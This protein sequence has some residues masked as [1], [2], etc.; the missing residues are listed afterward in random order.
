MSSELHPPRWLGLLVG[1]SLTAWCFTLTGLLL[2][3]GLSQAVDL[4][5]V[6]EYVAATFF[7]GLGLLFGYWTYCLFTLRYHLDR[8]GLTIRWG[9]IHQLIP[10]DR[11]QKL[12]PGR[13]LPPPRVSGVSW[14]GHHVGRGTVE[15]LGEVMF[16]A[17]HRTH[18][19]L[20]YVVTTG[21][22]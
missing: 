14:L 3:R 18:E 5:A 17:T 8:N 22:T 20:L 12:I 21:G 11:I 16:Y 10:I 15:D 9:D 7:F 1:C 19:E 13:E 6:G 2:W 4:P